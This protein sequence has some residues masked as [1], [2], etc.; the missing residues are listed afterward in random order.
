[1]IQLTQAVPVIYERSSTRGF[2]KKS[3]PEN[4]LKEILTAGTMAPNSGNMQPWEFIV[5]DTQ[6]M[7]EKVVETTYAGYYSKG[8]SNQHWIKDAGAI[9]VA[10]TNFKRTISAYGEDGNL[11]AQLDTAAAIQNMLLT[12]TAL[13]LG[14]CWIGGF[15]RENVKKLLN[16]PPYVTPISLVPLGYAS[17]KFDNKARIPVDL[18]T[19]KNQYN[20]PFFKVG[21]TTESL[22]K[23]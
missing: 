16:I 6:E 11:W 17:R 1:M 12:A 2:Q 20:V 14:G 10:C 9:I 19:H 15:N 23:N 7:K 22:I 3:I 21:N 13:G 5:I 8:A 18:I 4:L